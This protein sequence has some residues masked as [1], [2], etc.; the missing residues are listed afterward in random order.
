MAEGVEQEQE[1]ESIY[2]IP[3]HLEQQEMWGPVPARTFWVELSAAV[4]TIGPLLLTAHNPLF[5]IPA[6][7][8]AAP[9]AAPLS[10]PAEHGIATSVHHAVRTKRMLSADLER[11]TKARVSGGLIQTGYQQECRAILRAPTIN[12]EVAS[13][14]RKRLAR[15]GWGLLLDTYQRPLQIVVPGRPV[16]TLPYLQQLQRSNRAAAWDLAT[17]LRRQLHYEKLIERDRLLCVPGRDP[18]DLR[19]N[20]KDLVAALKQIGLEP[21][22]LDA[23][24]ELVDTLA[25][26]WGA[27]GIS[28]TGLPG[29]IRVRPDSV[30][31]DGAWARAYALGKLPPSVLTNWMA[32]LLDGDVACDTAIDIQ[33]VGADLVKFKLGMKQ[34]QLL[35]SKQTAGVQ[36][37]LAQVTGLHMALEQRLVLPY[38]LQITFVV[39]GEG[40]EE[41]LDA[42]RQLEQRVK[43]VGGLARLL[44]WEQAEG[45]RQVVPIRPMEMPR[46]QHTVETG[47]V[48]RMT[49]LAQATLQLDGGVPFGRAGDAICAFTV[50]HKRNPSK[51]M[52]WFAHSGGGKTFGAETYLSREYLAHGRRIFG[53]DQDEQQE[54]C[55]RF[56]MY[57]EGRT[58][59]IRRLADLADF[60]YAPD[61]GCVIFDLHECATD[62]L[63]AVIRGI[64][65]LTRAHILKYPAE[66]FFVIDEA[67]RTAEVGAADVLAEIATRW[68]HF[69]VSGQFLT[70]RP[71]DWLDL[72]VGKRVMGSCPSRWYGGQEP[73]EIDDVA[74]KAKW[75]TEEKEK[76]EGAGIGQGL[77]VTTGKRVWVDLF[78][79]VSTTEFAAF[80]TDGK[81]EAEVLA[82]PVAKA[83]RWRVYKQGEDV[84]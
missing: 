78:E 59:K 39:R 35:A 32:R 55:G 71:S 76:I 21:E 84:A 49:P 34:S 9:F 65:D 29:E 4:P 40:R 81:E 18:Q 62:A 13:W 23:D 1:V 26:C 83:R 12:L 50:F 17:F 37:A 48:A 22:V 16:E 28:K 24:N 51:H 82:Q 52:G 67:V 31:I 20:V 27:K 46:R 80:N 45:V 47:T 33:P 70:Q 42:A 77:L 75:S 6:L 14:A 61:D 3:T 56:V 72:P 58:P 57:L 8:A 10:P 41:M 25:Y 74:R 7:L 19:N 73:E 66:S 69:K 68:R 79:Q 38:R 63:A 30:Q 54:W 36:T 60:A 64:K 15:K 43:N 53:F 11:W 5:A 44:R 2:L